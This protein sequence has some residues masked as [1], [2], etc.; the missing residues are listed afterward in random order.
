MRT[1]NPPLR[2]DLF[3][4][5]RIFLLEMTKR[6]LVALDSS[7]LRSTFGRSTRRLAPRVSNRAMG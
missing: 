4:N 6:L 2:R 5:G 3:R 1:Q 7:L